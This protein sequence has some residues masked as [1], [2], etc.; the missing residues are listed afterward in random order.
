VGTKQGL[1]N[2]PAVKIGHSVHLPCPFGVAIESR[3]LNQNYTGN[4]SAVRLCRSGP[5]QTAQWDDAD[6]SMCSHQVISSANQFTDK[7]TTAS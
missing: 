6:V 7:T 1:F 4:Q 3:N 5:N 2:W